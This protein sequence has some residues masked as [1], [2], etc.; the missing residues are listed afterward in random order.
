MS[1]SLVH[2]MFI[3]EEQKI[4]ELKFEIL[5]NK[6]YQKNTRKFTQDGFLQ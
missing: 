4:H 1:Y 3:N 6:T 5:T 2:L